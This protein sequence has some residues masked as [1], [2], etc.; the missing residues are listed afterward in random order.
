M[1]EHSPE[2]PSCP[3]G[4]GSF[5]MFRSGKCSMVR[6]Q[7]LTFLLEITDVVSSRLKKRETFQH[8]IGVQFKSQH[9]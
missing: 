7:N 4:Q 9:L 5:K 1:C 2:V 6:V 8:V 3:A